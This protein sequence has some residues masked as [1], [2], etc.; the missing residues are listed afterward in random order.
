RRSWP[1]RGGWRAGGHPRAFFAAG[2]TGLPAPPCPPTPHRRG[3]A[4]GTLGRRRPRGRRCRRRP[5]RS[6]R[7]ASDRSGSRPG[8]CPGPGGSPCGGSGCRRRGPPRRGRRVPGG[9]PRR[10]RSGG[11]RPGRRP[12]G[13]RGRSER[14]GDP[15]GSRQV[16]LASR[17]RGHVTP[18]I[19]GAPGWELRGPPPP[20]GFVIIPRAAGRADVIVSARLFITNPDLVERFRLDAP[21]N[22][23][24][25]RTFYGGDDHGYTDYPT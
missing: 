5:G 10:G 22:P 12:G 6:G 15:P 17:G 3:F 2:W 25:V 19:L 4:W 14:V 11:L 13:K 20:F 9:A 21:L 24:D 16:L 23:W 1:G 18:D 8:R 7:G